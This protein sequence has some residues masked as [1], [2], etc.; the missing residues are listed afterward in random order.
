MGLH[1]L[2]HIS[3]IL[4]RAIK[5]LEEEWKRQRKAR[6]VQYEKTGRIIRFDPDSR[7][8]FDEI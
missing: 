8:Y 3:S 5:A 1:D 2:E 4:S 7:G 6:E